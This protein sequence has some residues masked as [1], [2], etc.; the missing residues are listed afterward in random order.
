MTTQLDDP[1]VDNWP[2]DR[3]HPIY[4]GVAEWLRNEAA[5]PRDDQP[6]PARNK[7]SGFTGS[8]HKGGRRR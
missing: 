8:K 2:P 3:W 4:D 1:T 6:M 7:A 5:P